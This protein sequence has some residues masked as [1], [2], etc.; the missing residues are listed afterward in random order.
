M[1]GEAS[2][3]TGMRVESL[4]PGLRSVVSLLLLFLTPPAAIRAQDSVAAVLGARVRFMRHGDL[5]WRQGRFESVDGDTLHIVPCASCAT[6][7]Y[8]RRDLANVETLIGRRCVHQ[9]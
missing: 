2:I 3:I 9:A 4:S 7:A 1:S 5:D 8:A 6:I